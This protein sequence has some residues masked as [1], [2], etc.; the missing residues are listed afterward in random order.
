MR[1]AVVLVVSVAVACFAPRVAGAA[2]EPAAALRQAEDQ[3]AAA[4]V[5]RDAAAFDRLLSPTFTLRGSP[6]VDRETWLRN[7]TTLCW[8][9]QATIS[10]F[11]VVERQGDTALVALVLTTNQDP[12]SCEPATVRSLLTDFWRLE[13][14]EWRLALRHSGPAGGVTA[15]FARQAPPPPFVE[16]SAEL[17]LVNTG[18]NSETRTLGLGGT[19][20][21]RPEAWVTDARL[22]F[23]R[24]ASASVETARSL[25][26]GVRQARRITARLDAFG[27]VE[28]LRNA[29]AGID[30]RVSVDAGFG[31]RVLTGDAHVLRVDGGVGYS[32]EDRV[33]SDTLSFALVNLG[34]AYRWR[35]SRTSTL[36]ENAIL[37]ASVDE[38]EDWR[39]GHALA[40]TTTVNRVFSVKLSHELKFVNRPVLGF[41]KTDTVLSA[42]LVARF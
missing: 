32:R 31:Y 40:F 13:N 41:E 25:V 29:F 7:A 38:Q 20:T 1:R 19:L 37:T 24:T 36:S 28:Y 23:V 2:Q 17:S 18:G 14:G 5:A 30:D 26:A 3:L 15:Q 10:D 42:A 34:G 12:N 6:D 22:A 4:L 21:W 39:F 27:R 9:T 33:A 8:G 16:G 11:R 35:I